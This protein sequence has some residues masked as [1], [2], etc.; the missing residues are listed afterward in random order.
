MPMTPRQLVR[1]FP[2]TWRA[3][4]GA[5]FEALLESS[6][7]TRRNVTDVLRRAA[8]EW[9]AHTVI[10]RLILAASLVAIG[11]A[12]AAGLAAISPGGL[13]DHGWPNGMSVAFGLVEMGMGWRFLWCALSRVRIEDGEQQV[14]ISALFAGFVA[15]QWG[16]RVVFV[17]TDFIS[18][19]AMT[20][21]SAMLIQGCI[22]TLAMSRI[23]PRGRAVVQLRTTP[24]A[25]P[26]GLL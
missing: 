14:W 13:Q 20:A 21:M 4:Y 19:S 25:R 17:R 12:L 5:E 16:A 10:G 24:S 22:Q 26:L 11:T 23:L 15:A 18:S 8:S 7:L 1:L 9:I 3:R 2:R 6:P